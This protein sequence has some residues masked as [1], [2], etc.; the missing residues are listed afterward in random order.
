MLQLVGRP[1]NARAIRKGNAE[2]SQIASMRCF[3]EA[4]RA[5][6]V[7]TSTI[8]DHGQIPPAANRINHAG[9]VIKSYFI[10]FFLGAPL[11]ERRPAHYKDRAG[12]SLAQSRGIRVVADVDQQRRFATAWFDCNRGARP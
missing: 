12:E 9:V 10:N 3:T 4:A 11:F 5:R 7:G 2:G 1:S 8:G 6:H